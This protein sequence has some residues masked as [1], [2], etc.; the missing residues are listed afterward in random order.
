MR[1][2]GGKRTGEIMRGRDRRENME[3]RILTDRGKNI[4]KLGN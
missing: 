2:E 1:R 4:E 3:G